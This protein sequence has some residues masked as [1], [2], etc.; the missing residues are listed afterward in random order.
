MK[1][2]VY[3]TLYRTLPPIRG[4]RVPARF[5]IILGISLAVLAAFGVRR[6]L[7][8][9]PG[10]WR[11]KLAF[12]GILGLMAFDLRP[13]LMLYP[14]WVDVPKIYE[15]LAGRPDVV[16][17]E[18]PFEQ[19]Q[20]FVTNELPFMYFSLWHWREMVNGYSGF[21][22]DSHEA[23]IK[24]AKDFPDAA[25]IAALRTHG[26]THVTVNCYFIK[27]CKAFMAALDARPEFKLIRSGDW[28]GQLTRL[29]EF[30][31]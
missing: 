31:R 9:W 26:V 18:F 15:D 22:L 3:P 4:M 10:G 5:S 11:R 20:P 21:T 30:G 17:A 16:L 23:L 13:S 2:V 29:Y 24:L 25:S 14:M 1:G 7:S 28:Q 27:D 8:R 6:L 12:A 19:N